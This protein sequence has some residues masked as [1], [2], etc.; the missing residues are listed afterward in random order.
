MY[1]AESASSTRS[2]DA[3]TMGSMNDREPA[4]SSCPYTRKP[5]ITISR[6]TNSDIVPPRKNTMDAAMAAT[7]NRRSTTCW[8]MV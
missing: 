8:A 1:G 3:S 5:P 7:A 6:H 4:P 2:M